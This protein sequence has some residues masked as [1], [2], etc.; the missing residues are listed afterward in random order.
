MPEATP[1]TSPVD[2]FTVAIAVLLLVQAP[3]PTVLLKVVVAAGH[4]EVVPLIVPALTE[5]LTVTILVATAVPQAF[6]TV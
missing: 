6:V 5:E 3:P 1:V 2:E 4:T